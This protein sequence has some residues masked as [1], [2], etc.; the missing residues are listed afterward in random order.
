MGGRNGRFCVALQTLREL[1]RET[2]EECGPVPSQ[3]HPSD[4]LKIGVSNR[5]EHF[6]KNIGME[7]NKGF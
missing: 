4:I 3:Y 1:T 5:T 7:L 6:N 2:G